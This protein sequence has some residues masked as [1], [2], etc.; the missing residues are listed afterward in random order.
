MYQPLQELQINDWSTYN[1]NTR[2]VPS[3]KD[4]FVDGFTNKLTT[5]VSSKMY[6][7]K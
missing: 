6:I 1:V 3:F 4:D 2:N 5:L 7:L